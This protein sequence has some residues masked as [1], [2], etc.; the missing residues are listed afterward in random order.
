M[1]KVRF[2]HTADLHLDTPFK[3]LGHLPESIFTQIKNSTFLSFER[4][5]TKAIQ[6]E[7]DFVL[8]AGDLFDGA[9]RSLKAQLF[10]KEQ[11][12]RLSEVGI[13]AYAIH[14]NHDHL[15]GKFVQLSWPDHVHFF[16]SSAPEMIPFYKDGQ[17]CA[18]IYGYSYPKRSVT[19]NI[20]ARYEKV[21][22][23]PF[24]IALLHG[25]VGGNTEHDPYAPSSLQ[26]LLDKP[27]DYWALGHIHKRSELNHEPPVVYAGNIQGLNRKE[28]GAKGCYL[29]E[30]SDEKPQLQFI[31]TAPIQWTSVSVSTEEIDE[32]DD[33]L[34]CMKDVI[35][36]HRSTDAHT[37]LSVDL[38]VNQTL[39]SILQDQST[40]DD[41]LEHLQ[42]SE[43]EE[44]T[45]VW[46]NRLNVQ[47]NSGDLLQDI[48]SSHFIEE[49]MDVFNNELEDLETVLQPLVK[50]RKG[51]RFIEQDLDQNEIKQAAQYL[52]FDSMMKDS[53]R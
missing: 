22:G 31:Q 18:H 40:L 4:M 20:A 24:H 38:K 11:F 33:L 45:F 52:L 43:E 29:V 7:V 9:N 27:F 10:L 46:I 1:R 32:V 48:G 26:E 23:A 36:T 49:V 50:H 21:D 42:Q 34:R 44:T 17:L 41:I 13:A 8:L 39:G 37:I 30:L 19:E 14:G 16:G 53:E 15:E 35:E 47:H 51:K 12:E 25:T 3:G 5:I 6:L 28:E 2:I